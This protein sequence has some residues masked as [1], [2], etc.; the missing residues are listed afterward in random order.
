MGFDTNSQDFEELFG[1]VRV[2]CMG[3]SAHRMG[4]FANYIMNFLGYKL[5]V[6]CKLEDMTFKAH[7]FSF[8]KVIS[9]YFLIKTLKYK[10][11]WFLDWSNNFCESWNGHGFNEYSPS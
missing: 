11:F 9:I 6:G 1:D 8:Y 7:R 3:G 4:M 10:C 2:V 5:P